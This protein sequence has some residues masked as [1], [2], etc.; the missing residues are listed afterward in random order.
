MRDCSKMLIKAED[1]IRD[2]KELA[3]ADRDTRRQA[4]QNMQTKAEEAMRDQTWIPSDVLREI[5]N[6]DRNRR[7]NGPRFD[8]R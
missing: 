8:R 4:R 3:N 2:W 1:K 6:R 5:E 7:P